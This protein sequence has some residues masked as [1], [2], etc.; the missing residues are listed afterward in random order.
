M[1]IKWFAEITY[2]LEYEKF[3]KN[4]LY[5]LFE[6]VYYIINIKRE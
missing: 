6:G 4:Y 3:S 2:L 1:V 5:F